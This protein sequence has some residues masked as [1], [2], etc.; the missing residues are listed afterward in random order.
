M[1][2]LRRM[3]EGGI[4]DQLGGGFCRY[5]VDERWNIPHFEKMLYDNGPLLGLYAD[6][7]RI[8]GDELFRRTAEQTAAWAM[9]EM[10]SPLGGY[11]SS[12]D[13]DSEHEEGKF[14]VWDR[15]EA[16]AIL[17]DD[18]LAVVE[19]HYG[20]SG[21]PN[22]EN[23]RWHLHVAEPLE[24]TARAL[25]RPLSECQDLLARA[26]SKLFA[27][28][29]RRVRPGR[30]EKLL[31][32]WNALMISG[33]A[34]AAGVFGRPDWIAS[35][36]RSLEF[37]RGTLWREGR[38]L[39]TFKDGRAHLNAYLDDHAFLLEALLE[40]MQAEF[41]PEDLEWAED[42][43]DVLL[44]RFEDRERG[45]FFFTSH[46]HERL[47]HRPKTGADNAMASGNAVAAFALQRLGHLTGERRYL[48]AAERTLQL[49]HPQMSRQPAGF[50]TM[51]A[52]LAEY[53]APPQIV[54]L[55][56]LAAQ[57]DEWKAA[58]VRN[59]RPDRMVL[60]I[61]AEVRGLPPLLD[62]PAG[63]PVNAWVCSGVSCLPPIKDM[64]EL[65]RVCRAAF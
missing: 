15:S 55:R 4:N 17:A 10:Q 23:R 44:E 50:A 32:S 27:A 2:T 43:A 13:A 58:L 62:K 24:Q 31:T 52:A 11:Y 9:R 26:R 49:F 33:M 57:A 16:V 65:E 60:A 12:L 8:S 45:G 14:Y 41:R 3:A 28:R 21:P 53:L 30:D 18:E 22:F 40:S 19:R 20:L 42:L 64:A 25:G 6:A 35:A 47:I 46:D 29:E 56:G 5:S 54:V 37:L 48:S 39:A 36:R 34:R 38:L 61:A 59:Y 63:D 51:A 7:W 1:T